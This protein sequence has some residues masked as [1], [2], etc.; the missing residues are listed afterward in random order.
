MPYT[1]QWSDNSAHIIYTG[2]INNEEIRLAHYEVNNDERFFDCP[3]LIL[4]IIDC[5]MR[6]VEVPKL[7]EVAGLD[8]G[9]LKMKD[10]LKIA[11]LA[12]KPENMQKA[13]TYIKLFKKHTSKIKLFDSVEEAI[14]WLN[15]NS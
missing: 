6:D 10:N 5:E 12:N 2:D 3:N 7:I 1:I 9:N 14:P 4:D 13:N 11:M 8:L 15:S